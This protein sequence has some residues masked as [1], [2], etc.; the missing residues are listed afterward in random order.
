M[1]IQHLMQQAQKMQ[2][3]MA[4]IEASFQTE[5]FT[6]EAGGGAVRATVGGDMSLKDIALGEELMKSGDAEMLQDLILVAVN[7][8]LETARREKEA[9]LTK[10]MGKAGAGMPGMF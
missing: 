1:N 6:A 10:L 3:K 2:K 9:R 8:A 5:R 7:G 4:E